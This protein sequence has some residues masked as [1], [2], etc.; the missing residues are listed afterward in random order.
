VLCVT[1]LNPWSREF[2]EKLIVLHL[3][4]ELVH[5][6]IH[7]F[8]TPNQITLV[9]TPTYLLKI[10][11]Y[12]SSHRHRRL[13]YRSTHQTPV[14]TC[15]LPHMSPCV[16]IRNIQFLTLSIFSIAKCPQGELGTNKKLINGIAFQLSEGPGR[17]GLFWKRYCTSRFCRQAHH[18][19]PDRLSACTQLE[20]NFQSF[21]TGTTS[22]NCRSPPL[23][24]LL[25]QLYPFHTSSIFARF[26]LIV[27]PLIRLITPSP[28]CV[29]FFFFLAGVPTKF[30]SAYFLANLASNMARLNLDV[31][32]VM[33]LPLG[34]QY[35]N[36][37][38]PHYAVAP[39]LLLLLMSKNSPEGSSREF[40]KC[41]SLQV[42]EHVLP[43]GSRNCRPE[44]PA[45]HRNESVPWN[46]QMN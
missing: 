35:T 32:T 14:Y 5:Y 39:L 25:S 1:E 2:C 6:C 34:G 10:Y 11:S 17:D 29:C 43:A 28:L 9:H 24:S 46:E 7:F 27:Y 23:I 3:T 40:S 41:S 37:E 20:L 26:V 15:C 33:R 12:I 18:G 45:S 30:L 8:P 36:H 31:I 22:Y 13:P 44:L 21:E 42:R 16:V 38:G 4:K 19:L